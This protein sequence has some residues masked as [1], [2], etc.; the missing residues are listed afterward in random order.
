MATIYRYVFCEDDAG[1]LGHL[2]V[3]YIVYNIITYI[4]LYDNEIWFWF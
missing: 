3:I 1:G 4:N 2:I